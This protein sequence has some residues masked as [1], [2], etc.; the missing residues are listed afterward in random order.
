M[1]TRGSKQRA[2]LVPRSPA[3]PFP[4]TQKPDLFIISPLGSKKRSVQVTGAVAA[5]FHS[6][7]FLGGRGGAAV[8][9]GCCELLLRMVPYVSLL[10]MLGM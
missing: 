5:S 9:P 2:K 3:R 1:D 4:L 8:V 7:R 6:P 10:T